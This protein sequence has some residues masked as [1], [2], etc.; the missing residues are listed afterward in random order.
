MKYIISRTGEKIKFN[1]SA[2]R[3]L[4]IDPTIPT[5]V[6]D[7]EFTVL[8]TRLGSQ[9]KSVDISDRSELQL[10][11][12]SQSFIQ[13]DVIVGDALVQDVPVDVI[14]PVD[15]VLSPNVEVGIDPNL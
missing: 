12:D 13:P 9:I 7:A 3:K 10:K 4:L 1:L 11:D 8:N 2:N 6:Q 14:S 5:E 15:D